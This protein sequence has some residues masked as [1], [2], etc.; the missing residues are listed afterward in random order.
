MSRAFARFRWS[1]TS[2]GSR[3][4]Q[5]AS[6][7]LSDQ[8][9]FSTITRRSGHGFKFRMYRSAPAQQRGMVSKCCLSPNRHKHA[10]QKT[11]QGPVSRQP[12]KGRDKASGFVG[13][14]L[15]SPVRSRRPRGAELRGQFR[16]RATSDEIPQWGM[17]GEEGAQHHSAQTWR[18]S[19]IYKGHAGISG[20]ECDAHLCCQIAPC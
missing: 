8:R 1:T 6:A 15:S 3:N 14:S 17:D 11:K 20:S 16:T 19:R 4:A 5:T 13:R 2:I 10:E 18:R 9:Y 7:S 12:Q